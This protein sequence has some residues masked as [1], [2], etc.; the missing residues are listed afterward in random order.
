MTVTEYFSD[1]W[2]QETSRLGTLA[3]IGAEQGKTGK[4][5]HKENNCITEIMYGMKSE[6]HKDDVNETKKK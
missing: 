6:Q 3:M 5:I 1:N 2:S 4:D